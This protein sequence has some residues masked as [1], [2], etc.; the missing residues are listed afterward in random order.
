MSE[1]IIQDA[2]TKLF[3]IASGATGLVYES[4]FTKP[5]IKFVFKWHKCGLTFEQILAKAS[6]AGVDMEET[7]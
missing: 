1:Y 4:S 3:G 6:K 2:D 7:K 5:Q